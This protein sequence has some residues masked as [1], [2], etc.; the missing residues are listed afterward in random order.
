[1]DNRS[2]TGHRRDHELAAPLG[3]PTSGRLVVRPKAAR[4]TVRGDPTMTD[5]YRASFES[6]A[7]TVYVRG[8]TI[9]I[10]YPGWPGSPNSVPCSARDQAAR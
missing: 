10:H 7:P 1:M 5:L 6:P 2:D 9:T 3:R 8:G 4:L